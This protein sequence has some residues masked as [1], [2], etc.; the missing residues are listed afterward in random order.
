MQKEG[1]NFE[2][3]V[4]CATSFDQRKQLLT[5]SPELRIE[6]LDKDFLACTDAYKEG[7]NWVLM[8][9]GQVVCYESQMLNEH[10]KNYVTHDLELAAIIHALKI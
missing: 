5:I 1:N 8:Q 9:E 4:E 10:E 3:T 2:W 6:N 7:L